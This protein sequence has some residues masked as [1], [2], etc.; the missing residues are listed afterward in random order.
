MSSRYVY[1]DSDAMPRDGALETIGGKAANL[2]LLR[3]QGQPVPPFYVVTTETFRTVLAAQKPAGCC[4]E[5]LGRLLQSSGDAATRAAA[6]L[7]DLIHGINW[8]NDAREVIQ[9]AHLHQFGAD[10]VVSVRSSAV[11]EDSSRHSFAGMYESVLD[12][13]SLDSVLTAI[14]QVWSS[15]FSERAIDYRRRHALPLHST[16]MAV[17][18]QQMIRARQSGIMFTCNPVTGS[19]DEICI[20]AVTGHGQLLV[21]GQTNGESYQVRRRD[22]ESLTASLNRGSQHVLSIEQLKHVVESGIAIEQLFGSPQD[23]E[24][25]FDKDGAFFVLQAR[26]ITSTGERDNSAVNHLVWDNS[27]IIESYAGITTPLTF[28]FIRRAYG[29]VYRCFAEVMGISPRVVRTH[30]AT[31]DNMLG[32]FRGRVY[33]NLKNW[34]RLVRLF[35]GY[36]YNREFMETMMGVREPLILEDKLTEPS[37]LRRWCVEFPA[38][39]ILLARI[40]WK[41]MRLRSSIKDFQRRFDAHYCEWRQI[42]F[43]DRQPHELLALYRQM[44]DSLLWNWKAPIVNDF[45]VMIFYGILKKLC[46]RWCEDQSGSLQNGLLCATG[47]LESAKPARLLL[48]L[49]GIAA[50]NEH[51]RNLILQEPAESLPQR[52]AADQRFEPF[53]TLL[54]QY[55]AEYGLRCANE[56]KLEALSYRDRPELLYEIIRSY[57]LLDDVAMVDRQVHENRERHRLQDAERTAFTALETQSGWWPRKAILRFVLER[58]RRGI[59]NR[60]NLRFARTKIYRLARSMFRA[61]GERFASEGILRNASDVFYLTTDEIWDYIQGT[62][63][64]TNLRALAAAR[65]AEYDAYEAGDKFSPPNRFD[66]RGFPYVGNDF[67]DVSARFE[68]GHSTILE[69]TSC[70]PGIVVGKVQKCDHPAGTQGIIGEIL[71]AERTDPGWVTL[72][73]AFRGIL[74]ER[75]SPLSHSAIVAREMGIPTIV[76]ISG[77]TAQLRTGQYVRMDGARG[78]VEILPEQVDVSSGDGCANNPN[79]VV[80]K[81]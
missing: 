68:A 63:V 16:G 71:I 35:P 28:S 22:P 44:E 19:L 61:I 2:K 31:F 62:A 5:L 34:Y 55:L 67:G 7:R 29:I 4:D 1:H 23:I 64:T 78:T 26:P 77:L 59:R 60:E 51:L 53:Q 37:A 57:L 48:Q 25:C 21:H 33:Y 40:S 73:P 80:A 66:T 12:V 11:G 72:F 43:H 50:E 65:R 70:C 36:Q 39:V 76:G 69:G 27:N 47:G 20:D 9:S 8:S 45:F 49:A 54:N 18:V 41:F 38:L 17:V 15:C 58:A 14:R 13:C 30:R 75:G 52:V 81:V 46:V 74:I 32:L 10:S 79:A 6:E 56:L 24:F 3:E 42:D